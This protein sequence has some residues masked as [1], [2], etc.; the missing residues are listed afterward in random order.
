MQQHV[1]LQRALGVPTQLLDQNEVVQR[2]PQVYVDDVIGAT[3]CATDGYSDPGAMARSLVQIATQRG[4]RLYEHT[5]TTSILVEHST[6]Q[7][8]Q[9]LRETI[10]THVVVNA[11]G[12]YAAL[13]ARLAGIVDL[14]VY[15]VRRQLYLTEPYADMSE[16]VPMVVDL[17]TGFHFRRR[18]DRLLITSPLPFDEEKLRNQQLP[19][20]PDAFELSLDN[21]FW[22]STLHRQI[23]HRCPSLA[24]V[25]IA[26]VW[27]GLYEM[28]PDEHPILGKTEVE[29]F[30]CACGFSGH[31]FMHA[32][33]AAKLL[34]ELI[35]D[36]ESTTYPIAP[37]A[38][39][40]FRSGQLLHTTR[41]L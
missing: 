3:F 25:P 37:F 2:L 40:R 10:H 23:Q 31:G 30:L 41:L 11:A 33:M 22:Q 17:S 12:A 14:P 32:P 15:P 7:A 1:Q 6:V 35:V 29:G 26:Q 39:E 16:N 13:V 9:T 24:S 5:P 4:V 27:S 34:T 36:G 18:A 19:L 20:T 28:T 38:L 8:V 21:D